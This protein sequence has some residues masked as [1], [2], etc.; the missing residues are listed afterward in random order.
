MKP[1]IQDKIYFFLENEVGENKKLRTHFIF[2][3]L[4]TLT[5]IDLDIGA[6]LH[7]TPPVVSS[8]RFEKQD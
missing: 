3:T 8:Y 6:G 2:S 5:K 1:T 4:R 7:R